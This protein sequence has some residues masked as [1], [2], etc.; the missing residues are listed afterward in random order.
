M[1]ARRND[2][3]PRPLIGKRIRDT[4]LRLG[5][6]QKAFADMIGASEGSVGL[7][8][9]GK[10]RPELHLRRLAETT[11]VSESWILYGTDRDEQDAGA[12]VDR[13]A[14]IEWL[15]VGTLTRMDREL[16][17]VRERFNDNSRVLERLDAQGDRIETHVRESHTDA[18][19]RAVTAD[20]PRS[21]KRAE[22]KSTPARI[23]RQT[24]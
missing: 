7:W 18:F 3:D 24:G 9:R 8:E 14:K 16:M 17:D 1:A 6:S 13:V 15:V 21:P 19:T 4:R 23:R 11:N 12:L 10:A 2:T 22:G 20:A 5:L